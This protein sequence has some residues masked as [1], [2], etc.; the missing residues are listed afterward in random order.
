MVDSAKRPAANS[1]RSCKARDSD[2]EIA[3]RGRPE[4]QS[5]RAAGARMERPHAYR[6]GGGGRLQLRRTEL[7]LAERNRA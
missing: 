4:D 1:P 7:P 5:G 2:G 6:H 3:T